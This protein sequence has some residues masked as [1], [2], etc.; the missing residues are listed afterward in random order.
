M[1]EK[2]KEVKRLVKLAVQCVISLAE[3]QAKIVA[4]GYKV[5]DATV[6]LLS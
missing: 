4:L 6:F 2:E 3:Y 5:S 1:D